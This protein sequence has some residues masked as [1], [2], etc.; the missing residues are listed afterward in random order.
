[1]LKNKVPT[2]QNDDYKIAKTTVKE[3]TAYCPFIPTQN[4]P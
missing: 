3:E 2:Q 1:M 4:I